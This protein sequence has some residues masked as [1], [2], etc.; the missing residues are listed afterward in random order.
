MGVSKDLAFK[1]NLNIIKTSA[2]VRLASPINKSSSSPVKTLYK[3]QL[4][5]IDG[6]QKISDVIS[7]NIDI[8]RI[9][10]IS[11]E[12]GTFGAELYLDV[13]GPYID[14]ISSIKFNNLSS[15]NPKYESKEIHEW[16][17]DA[18]THG[19]VGYCRNHCRNSSALHEQYV[20]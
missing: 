13:I 16:L 1:N 4:S 20:V 2:L 14:P 3:N 11:I 8:Q 10:N 18:R 19:H 15:I 7:F 12:E 9:T 5:V 17:Y 6:A